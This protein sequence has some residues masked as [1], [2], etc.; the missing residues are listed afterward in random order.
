ML[1]KADESQAR[2]VVDKAGRFIEHCQTYLAAKG[3]Q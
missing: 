1:G 3:Y 2:I